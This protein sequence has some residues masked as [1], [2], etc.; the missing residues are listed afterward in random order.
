MANRMTSLQT[1][2]RNLTQDSAR[3]TPSKRIPEFEGLRGLLAAWVIFGHILLFSGFEYSQG[4][5]GIIF[6]PV[7][8]VYVFMMLSGFVVTSSLDSHSASGIEFLRRRFFRI[9]PVYLICLTIA[10][11]MMPISGIVADSFRHTELGQDT[12]ARLL[13]AGENYNT[14]VAADLLLLQDLLP[15]TYY[16]HAHE[17]F[18]PPTWSLSLEWI[19]YLVMP[20]M[21]ALWRQST[22]IRIIGFSSILI[23]T[24]FSHHWITSVCPTLSLTIAGYFLTGIVSYSVWK[25]LP[26]QNSRVWKKACFWA[27]V[28]VGL[29][30]LPFAYKIWLSAM[31]LVL[32]DRFHTKPLW[33]LE[34]VRS[35]LCS[36]PLAFLG[37]IS[38]SS[39]LVHWTIVEACLF[40]ALPWN[41]QTLGPTI[42]AIYCCATV[43]PL[44]YLTSHWLFKYVE[45]PMIQLGSERLA[46]KQLQPQDVPQN[47]LP[48]LS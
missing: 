42:I 28:I 14:Y 15:R 21:V 18:L 19:F 41:L 12:T 8:G 30:V 27:C 7:L 44:T 39:Y 10:I 2:C 6:S 17:T 38:F 36:A 9:Y 16:P 48:G 32:Y 20:L 24:Y 43:F 40:V 35:A 34:V 4:L 45:Q 25:R 3:Q 46:K 1:H 33:P 37:R 31:M 22:T 26:L 13:E 23:G 29:V 5:F 11:L 47:S